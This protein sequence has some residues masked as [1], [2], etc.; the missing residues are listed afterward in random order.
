M[1]LQPHTFRTQYRWHFKNRF[2]IELLYEQSELFAPTVN[3]I[4]RLQKIFGPSKASFGAFFP[5]LDEVTG[6]SQQA[7]QNGGK[8]TG[9]KMILEL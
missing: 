9:S 7:R 6:T 4:H 1:V 3:C 2:K 8:T 5:R